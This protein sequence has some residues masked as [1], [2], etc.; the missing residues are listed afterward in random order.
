MHSLPRRSFLQQT[1]AAAGLAALRPSL[2]A[3]EKTP[4]CFG[5]G[6]TLYGM[7]SLVLEDALKTCA[8]IG[9]DSVELCL[10]EGYPTEPKLLPAAERPRLRESLAAHK[11]R[12][13]GLMENFSLLADEAKQVQQIERLKAAAQLAYDLSPDAPPPLETVL[14]GKPAEWDQVKDKMAANLHAWAEAATAA[15]IVIAIKAHIMSAVQNPERL[16]W[17]LDAV[18]SPAIKAAYDY[19]HFQLQNLALEDTMNALI[20][21]TSFVHVKDGRITAEGK[22]EFLLPGEGTTD[23]GA[24]FR[25]LQAQGYRG[26]VVVEVSAMIFKKEGYDP[27]AAAEKSFAG[28]SAGLEKAGLARRR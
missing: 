8:T 9:Y 26:D 23:Y 15:K 25:K 1:L 18:K 14:G 17:L 6:Y 22:V 16:L 10:L 27:K 5:L 13:S 2:F 7:K 24:M 21:R 20:P 4:A 28:L 3:Q 19:S 11:L 12:I